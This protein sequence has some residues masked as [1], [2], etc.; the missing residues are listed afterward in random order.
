MTWPDYAKNQDRQYNH[1]PER[2]SL[3][4]PIELARVGT[5]PP[6]RRCTL[7]VG[8]SSV[9]PEQTNLRPNLF[10]EGSNFYSSISQ[11]L[12]AFSSLLACVSWQ[13]GKPKRNGNIHHHFRQVANINQQPLQT[14]I[15]NHPIIFA[16][17]ILPSILFKRINN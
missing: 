13:D 15:S 16:G 1:K 6:A 5:G 8:F 4:I 9:V 2:D 7:V 14:R 11:S 12:F 17:Q 10:L 3:I